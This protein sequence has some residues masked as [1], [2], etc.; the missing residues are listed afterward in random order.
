MWQMS[1]LAYKPRDPR[2]VDPIL[3]SLYFWR[4]TALTNG[5]WCP[6]NWL[7]EISPAVSS[8]SIVLFSLKQIHRDP[9]ILCDCWFSEMNIFSQAYLTRNRVYIRVRQIT[10]SYLLTCPRSVST[11]SNSAIKIPKG[12]VQS[13]SSSHI[14]QIYCTDD[15]MFIR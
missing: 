4:L 14:A 8:F 15:I 6:T 9:S 2:M 13:Y 7:K 1:W 10:V 3:V 11:L 12:D 5:F